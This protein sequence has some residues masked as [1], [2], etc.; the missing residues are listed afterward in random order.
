MQFQKISILTPHRQDWNFLG[1]GGRGS[2]R[3]KTFK[4]CS[5]LNWSFQRGDGAL[6]KNHSE[7]EV[8]VWMFSRYT[9][10]YYELRLAF[11]ADNTH[12]F[13][14]ICCKCGRI[15]NS[16]RCSYTHLIHSMLF[17][18]FMLNVIFFL[19]RNYQRVGLDIDS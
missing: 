8:Y 18:Y 3:P 2:L 17:L 15:N 12:T 7:G 10:N 5:R 11:D 1:G 19:I 6:E 14:H 16:A 13:K 9:Q 4:K